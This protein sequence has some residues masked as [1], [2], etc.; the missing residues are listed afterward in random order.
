[1][2]R[3]WLTEGDVCKRLGVGKQWVRDNRQSLGARVLPAK[4]GKAWRY[5]VAAVDRCLVNPWE[6]SR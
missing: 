6:K 4:K 2:D 5:N 1:M 3:V